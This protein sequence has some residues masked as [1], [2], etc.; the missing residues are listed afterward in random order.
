[1]PWEPN[2]AEYWGKFNEEY[3]SRKGKVRREARSAATSDEV[4]K[5]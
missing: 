4:P 5:K 2:F 3:G 1:M